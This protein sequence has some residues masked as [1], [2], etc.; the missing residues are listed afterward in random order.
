ME[1]KKKLIKDCEF[2]A[3]NATC[4]CFICKE[5]FCDSCFKMVHDKKNKSNHKKENIDMY[6]P[7]DLKCQEHPDNPLSLFC[8]EEKGNIFNY[9][10]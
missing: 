9:I 1:K 6:V 10:I 2:C 8:V 5:Y 7:I 4:L 3:I